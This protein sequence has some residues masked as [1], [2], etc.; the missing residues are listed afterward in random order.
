[1]PTLHVPATP[2]S[3]ALVNTYLAENIS[4][5]YAALLPKLELLAEELLVNVFL[6]SRPLD[7]KNNASV[8]CHEIRLDDKTYLRMVV[9]DWGERF[10]PFQEGLTPDLT[11]PAGDRPV[12]GLGIHLV[13]SLTVHHGYARVEDS[14][15]IELYF[16]KP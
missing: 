9:Q 6:H 8:A 4:P 11:L 7:G 2:E 16:N 1:M 12:G 5:A 15:C 13:R 14:N 10:D 3:L